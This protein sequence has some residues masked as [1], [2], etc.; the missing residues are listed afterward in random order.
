MNDD[1][2]EFIGIY[3]GDGSLNIREERNS[4]EFK[5]VGNIHDEIQTSITFQKPQAKSCSGTSNQKS[6]ILEEA[7]DCTFARKVS[8]NTWKG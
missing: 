7:L 1:L 4:Y 2:A 5:F 6:W 3:L 8:Q